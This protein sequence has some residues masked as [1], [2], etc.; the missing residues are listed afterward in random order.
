MA[1]T[2]CLIELRDEH[3]IDRAAKQIQGRASLARA[4]N[5]SAAAIGN[6]KARGIPAEYCPEIERLTG[7]P[8]EELRPDVQWHV[9]RSAGPAATPVTEQGT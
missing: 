6:W 3:P 2:K 9:L 4:L 5:V 7:V 8:C 1:N